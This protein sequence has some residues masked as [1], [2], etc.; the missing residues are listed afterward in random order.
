MVPRIE[1]SFLGHFNCSSYTDAIRSL[2]STNFP[3]LKVLVLDSLPWGSSKTSD[4][5]DCAL[6]PC[7]KL[8]LYDS[9]DQVTSICIV[10]SN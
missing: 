2:M 6:F 5:M 9:I 10:G 1:F 8:E 4:N 7:V 3:D